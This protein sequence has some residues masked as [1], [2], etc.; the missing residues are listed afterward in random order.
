M[1]DLTKARNKELFF[2]PIVKHLVVFDVLSDK[3]PVGY[4]GERII[5][6]LTEEAYAK[7]KLNVKYGYIKELEHKHYDEEGTE[8]I[9]IEPLEAPKIT[10]E[11]LDYVRGLAEENLNKK[12]LIKSENKNNMRR[13]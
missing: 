4:P 12:R 3:S 9:L 2:Q 10:N 11:F 8:F 7:H 13:K 6:F 5:T 1:I